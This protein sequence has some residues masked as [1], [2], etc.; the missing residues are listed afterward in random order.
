MKNITCLLV[1]LFFVKS[2]GQDY[3]DIPE[4]AFQT[5]LNAP[6]DVIQK[7]EGHYFIDFGKSFFGTVQI[8]S[9]VAQ[10]DSLILL[11]R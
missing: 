5:V 3:F 11:L 9:K 4:T 2:R 7:G 6:V 10:K 8:L 1:L